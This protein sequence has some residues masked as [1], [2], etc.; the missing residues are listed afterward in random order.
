MVT[1]RVLVACWKPSHQLRWLVVASV[2]GCNTGAVGINECRDIEFARC[3]AAAACGTIED[4][5]SCQRFYRDH[6][7]HGIAGDEAPTE[8]AQQA[9]VAAIEDAG[10]CAED[11][12]EMSRAACENATLGQGGAGTAGASQLDTSADSRTV[13]QFVANPWKQPVCGYLN[14]PAD[15][16]MGGAPND[17]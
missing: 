11:D 9:C 3:E 5:E 12:P 16:A 14:P 4:V 6:C 8:S 2:L 15:D 13:C 10:R 1:G 17:G 7:L